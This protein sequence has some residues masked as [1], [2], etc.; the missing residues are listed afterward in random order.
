MCYILYIVSDRS[1]LPSSS[2]FAPSHSQNPTTAYAL[3][4]PTSSGSSTGTNH[5]PPATTKAAK[6]VVSVADKLASFNSGDKGPSQQATATDRANTIDTTPEDN[7]TGTNS[8]EG[9]LLDTYYAE[10]EPA[11]LGSTPSQNP[12]APDSHSSDN[13]ESPK[14]PEEQPAE[15]IDLAL[16]PTTQPPSI[17]NGI[18]PN[19]GSK[20]FLQDAGKAIFK[21]TISPTT[22]GQPLS[23]GVYR[24]PTRSTTD[25]A[26]SLPRPPRAHDQKPP[27]DRVQTRM[28]ALPYAGV[29]DPLPRQ[30]PIEDY[31]GIPGNLHTGVKA[32]SAVSTAIGD[33]KEPIKPLRKS[34][35]RLASLV[36][37]KN[38]DKSGSSTPPPEAPRSSPPDATVA[39]N[40][41]RDRRRAVAVP[42]TY[43]LRYNPN[44][45]GPPRSS[46]LPS[47]YNV[48]GIS[49]NPMSP[50]RNKHSI[51][52]LPGTPNYETE[53][54]DSKSGGMLQ[55]LRK[56]S[57]SS[58]TLPKSPMQKHPAGPRLP[59][60]YGPPARSNAHV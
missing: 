45:M 36:S 35:S 1:N 30:P 10:A 14:S 18:F 20:Y 60:T 13:D 47:T 39:W 53:Q 17:P 19:E 8:Y 31:K 59:G 56:M 29:T 44:A 32:T 26:D 16:D 5:R 21:G 37:R 11:A 25:M 23:G 22:G 7:D 46:P 2:V 51:D 55:R 33:S 54:S 48:A 28:N 49:G 40:E 34:R 57:G 6:A 15:S 52:R 41:T 43:E 3:S 42:E 27:I 12:P 50:P 4:H 38:D 24:F 9:G 58:K